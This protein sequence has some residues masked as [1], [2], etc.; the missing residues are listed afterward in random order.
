MFESC[1]ACSTHTRALNSKVMLPLFSSN[2]AAHAELDGLLVEHIL[3]CEEEGSGED[4]LGDLGGN[5]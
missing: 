5:A 2:L 3:E 4:T 1:A